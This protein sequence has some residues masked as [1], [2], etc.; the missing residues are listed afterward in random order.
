MQ[1]E[2]GQ[3]FW[4]QS[5]NE[6]FLGHEESLRVLAFFYQ[7]SPGFKALKDL[8]QGLMAKL[9]LF[10]G[11]EATYGSKPGEDNPKTRAH[12]ANVAH[13]K[14]KSGGLF[15]PHVLIFIFKDYVRVWVGSQNL[16]TK[17]FTAKRGCV[18]EAAFVQDFPIWIGGP[19][20]PIQEFGK[21]LADFLHET[22]HLISSG[23]ATVICGDPRQQLLM[24][25]EDLNKYNLSS[26]VAQLVVAF[27]GHGSSLLIKPRERLFQL[28]SPHKQAE[29]SLVVSNS[30]LSV[31]EKNPTFVESFAINANVDRLCV[32]A[33]SEEDAKH[34]YKMVDRGL[35]MD[36]ITLQL[37]R[38]K[39][40]ALGE[41]LAGSF[42]HGK[43][44][45]CFDAD[46]KEVW[47]YIGGGT[48]PSPRGGNPGR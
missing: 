13:V 40:K 14:M 11:D 29:T 8:G 16:L 45:V 5:A 30:F 23:K 1:Y 21:D 33:A 42:V 44:A 4:S 10:Y 48:S 27:P 32:A 6:I 35:T 46:K 31:T 22:L 38:Y 20:G 28:S 43:V 2:G 47:A 12:P 25:L 37:V 19:A 34:I 24:T 18:Q 36:D 3:V 41:R 17:H 39:G 26:S 15:H 7:Y 9:T